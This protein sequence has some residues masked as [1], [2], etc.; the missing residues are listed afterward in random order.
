MRFLFLLF[1]TS[2][3]LFAQQS[4]QQKAYRYYVDGE[5]QNAIE[6]YKE[7]TSVRYSGS[8]FTPYYNSLLE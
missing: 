5:Y 1:L 7:L 4:D 3:S 2:Y 6:I 8:Y